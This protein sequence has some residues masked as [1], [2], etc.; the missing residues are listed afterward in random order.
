MQKRLVLKRFVLLDVI[1]KTMLQ[2]N[3]EQFEDLLKKNNKKVSNSLK[4][5]E[6]LSKEFDK[7][8]KEM[9]SAL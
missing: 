9:I 5:I 3:K 8:Y 4:E 2:M 7:K 1:K 6:A